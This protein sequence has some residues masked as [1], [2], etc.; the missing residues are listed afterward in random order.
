MKPH[1]LY[2]ASALL[3]LSGAV[4]AAEFTPI[5]DLPPGAVDSSAEGISDDGSVVVGYGHGF[6]GREAIRWTEAGLAG[7]GTLG[8][9]RTRDVARACSADG[10]VIVGESRA[11]ENNQVLGQA[12]RWTA[13]TGMVGLGYLDSTYRGSHGLDCSPDGSVVVGDSY[14]AS[15][16]NE[17]FRWTE[18]TGMVGMGHPPG[19]ATSARAVSPDGALVVGI[20]NT[21]SVNE[22]GRWTQA[23]GWEGLGDL[24]GG[25][26][27]GYAQACSDDGSVIVGFSSNAEGT[28][29]FRWTEATGM[30]GLEDLPG[31][32]V[33]SWIG[34]CTADA[35]ILVGCGSVGTG[36]AGRRAAVWD[37]EHGARELSDVLDDLGLAAQLNGWTLR[38]AR[39]V[40]P[41]GR[42]ICGYGTN[43]SGHT[44]GFRVLMDPDEARW[45][46]P[47][48]GAWDDLTNWDPW[49]PGATTDTFIEPDHGL[50]VTGPTLATTVASL[51]IGSQ[52]DGTAELQVQSAGPVTVSGNLD[53]GAPGD[54]LIHVGGGAS[55]TSGATR[56]AADANTAGSVIIDGADATWTVTG[57]E[58]V[59]VGGDGWLSPAAGGTGSVT[60]RNG[61]AGSFGGHVVLAAAANSVAD[62]DITAGSS[63]AVVGHVRVGYAGS[64]DLALVGGG[65]LDC[66]AAWMAYDP[67]ATGTAVVDGEGSAWR[68]DGSATIA[69]NGQADL[70][71][72]GGALASFAATTVSGGFGGRATVIATDA[73]T[74][75]ETG[76]LTIAA[77]GQAELH[78]LDGATVQT[79]AVLAAPAADANTE[80]VIRGAATSWNTGGGSLA[81]APAGRAQL[82]LLDG[83]GLVCGD[84][85]LAAGPAGEAVARVDGQASAWTV[86][87]S[88]WVGG[89]AGGG[90]GTA[91][92][93]VDANARVLADGDV[94]VWD[95]GAVHLTAGLLSAE[96]VRLSATGSP[97]FT[98]GPDSTLRVNGLVGFGDAAS[99]AGALQ[100]GHASSGNG[101]HAVGAGQG[102]AVA[103]RLDVGYDA[104]GLLTV[105]DGGTVTSGAG[106][107]GLLADANGTAVV[108]GSGSAWTV[109][110][111]CGV[112]D[113]GLLVGKTGTARLVVEDGGR[114]ACVTGA[115]GAMPGGTGAVLLDGNGAALSVDAA[116]YVGG[117][118]AGPGGGAS[119]SVGAGAAV[120]VGGPLEAWSGGSIGI[121]GG[122]V[123]AGAFQNAGGAFTFPAG[124]LTVDGGAFD[125]GV[126]D[127]ELDGNAG[128]VLTLTNGAS[129][130]LPGTLTV[131]DADAGTLRVL[132][133]SSIESASVRVAE[134]AGSVGLAVVDGNDSRWQT[135]SMQVGRGG[136][137]GLEVTN[138]GGV[139]WAHAAIG[140]GADANGTVRV[141]GGTF[142]A[143]G[144][145]SMTVG[146]HGTGTL[147]VCAGGLVSSG[148]P[149]VGSEPNSVG[150]AFVSGDGTAWVAAGAAIRVGE[151][152]MGRLEVTDGARLET[153]SACVAVGEGSVGGVLIDDGNWSCSDMLYVGGSGVGSLE[154]RGGGVLTSG[155]TQIGKN[156]EGVGTVRLDGQ[157]TRWQAP[158][159]LTVG[160]RGR[161]DVQVR[162]GALLEAFGATLGS[163]ARA[164]G[165][166]RLDDANWHNSGDFA[167]GREGEGTFEAVNGSEVYTEYA[168][169]IGSNSGGNGEARIDASRWEVTDFL[170]VGAAGRGR[171]T[172]T[173]G[174][175]VVS[176]TAY[177]GEWSGSDGLAVVTRPGS[178]C[179]VN[180]DLILGYSAGAAGRLE[181]TGGATV[182]D[183]DGMVARAAGS[184]AEVLVSGPGSLWDN[185][186]GHVGGTDRGWGGAGGDGHVTVTDHAEMRA[187]HYLRIWR[188][189]RLELDGG[190]LTVGELLGDG[191][192]G[193]LAF[194]S[195]TLTVTGDLALDL[196]GPLHPVVVLD[197]SRRLS[198]GGTATVD[199]HGRITV[200]GGHFSAGAVAGDG[201]LEFRTGSV[202]LTASGLDVAPGG[203]LGEDVRLHANRQLSVSGTVDIGE[204]GLLTVD[205][206]TL[207]AGAVEN[208]GELL[209]TGTRPRVVAAALSNTG[210]ILGDG[211]LVGETT[212][213]ADGRLLAE[214]G[215]RLVLD[216]SAANHG[217][218]ELTGGTVEVTGP[219]TNAAGGDILGRGTLSAGGLVNE[220]D[221]ALSVGVTDVHGDANNAPGGGV[222]VSGRADVTFWDDVHNAGDLFRVSADAS[223]TFFGAFSGDGISGDGHVYFEED[224]SP[225]F[226]AG[227]AAFGG[228]VTFGPAGRLRF[229]LGPPDNSDPG[230]PG[231]DAL[232]VAGDVDLD[233]T[234]ELTW[235]ADAGDPQTCFGGSY[236]VVVCGGAMSGELAEIAGELV[237]YVDSIER[238]PLGDGRT[239]LRVTLHDLLGGDCTLDG[240]VGR[241]DLGVLREHFGMQGGWREGDLNADGVVDVRDYV[242][243]KKHFGAHLPGR[244]PEPTALIALALTGASMLVRRWRN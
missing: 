99:F 91:T 13:E 228:N 109:S 140:S 8:G 215:N 152:G 216:G 87:G 131:A 201:P 148:S 223:A 167:I 74:R 14:Y 17:A 157:G 221:I 27:Y 158:R 35:S 179:T 90:G 182:E 117:S 192:P 28:V 10:S 191:N 67:C 44:E 202:A 4:S 96:T 113:G 81:L 58:D 31:G 118:A 242:A 178:R 197:E 218:V 226:S 68:S 33:Y 145:G 225:G 219:L 2:A 19:G 73:N 176:Q 110:D 127:F 172:V 190:T 103:G 94:G 15:W 229:E 232:S 162:D 46:S 11:L 6:Y 26:R 184:T 78:A 70:A 214:A 207:R 147:E 173:D 177:I 160:S 243:Y 165:H 206:T 57:T 34:G 231:Y 111:P 166:M 98:T 25:S 30:V 236:D 53:V 208:A 101:S 237:D 164:S 121:E 211:R 186:R 213:A 198:V 139:I 93:T 61:A 106:T 241:D 136:T 86:N 82:D 51:S 153:G 196:D 62:V 42:W 41:D 188:T 3:A 168:A 102:L 56:I 75:F 20:W 120:A 244:V 142:T 48:S 52:V 116:L 138:G 217:T 180:G 240:I 144:S 119:L 23:T 132:A 37:T 155:S 146:C 80:I 71:V 159:G 66:D 39:A 22:P 83:A 189:G 224:V 115:V 143:E 200:D 79:G 124:T 45:V 170:S 104:N 21:G 234:L 195:G 85:N 175:I 205:G 97:Q 55:L 222:M 126:T 16:K 76:A 174:G 84:A 88:L 50:T 60:F 163:A 134:A 193:A 9:D 151:E 135:G 203:L 18:A 43:P 171:L 210:L 130:T 47:T 199:T 29:P 161:G 128:P 32:D 72:S 220:G 95:A 230:N 5:G 212:N 38:A 108:S 92:L 1:A 141:D 181:I 12:F 149:T 235:L 187:S 204:A 49:K 183:S 238:I 227:V 129:A 77:H 100:I 150:R 89:S 107:V 7:L 105:T 233:G 122:D 59:F 209:L 194:T 154:V 137:G 112:L 185:V 65:Q 133:G 36:D 69:F 63:C 64:A 239:A 123:T 156:V 169:R 40:T 125:P 54:A 24:P 114:V